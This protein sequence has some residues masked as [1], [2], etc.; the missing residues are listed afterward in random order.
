MGRKVREVIFMIWERK[1]LLTMPIFR[2]FRLKRTFV[3]D[4]QNC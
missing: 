2:F 3:S 4:A 1:G